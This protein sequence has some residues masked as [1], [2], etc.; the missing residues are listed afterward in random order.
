M[1]V[2]GFLGCIAGGLAS[3]IIGNRSSVEPAA[4]GRHVVT[5]LG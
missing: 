1:D 5:L 3:Q 4:V 2:V